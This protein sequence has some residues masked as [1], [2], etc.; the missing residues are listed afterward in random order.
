MTRCL[1]CLL[2]LLV[3]GKGLCSFVLLVGT[4]ELIRYSTE[5]SV[6]PPEKPSLGNPMMETRLFSFAEDF[7]GFSRWYLIITSVHF[8]V[9]YCRRQAECFTSGVCRGSQ[10]DT[11]LLNTS[12]IFKII[13]SKS[14]EI[15]N[16]SSA[17]DGCRTQLTSLG[18]GFLRCGLGPVFCVGELHF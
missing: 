1:L 6:P 9:S 8:R 7:Q 12:L 5:V 18:P 10:P 2:C 11:G 16:G 17:R 15:R 4:D 13:L 3:S 14:S